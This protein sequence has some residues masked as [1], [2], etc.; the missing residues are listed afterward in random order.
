[1]CVMEPSRHT[2]EQI[3][4]NTKA[5]IGESQEQSAHPFCISIGCKSEG[6]THHVSFAGESIITLRQFLTLPEFNSYLS[7]KFQGFCY[8][9]YSLH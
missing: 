1:M 8:N 3:S 9:T 7:E 6:Y 4:L 2:P 5:S